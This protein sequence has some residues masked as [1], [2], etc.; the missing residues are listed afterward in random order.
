MHQELIAVPGAT[1]LAMTGS[2]VQLALVIFVALVLFAPRVIPPLLRLLGVAAS[3][4]L[5]ARRRSRRRT[6]SAAAPAPEVIPPDRPSPTLRASSDRPLGNEPPDPEP[7][8]P[9]RVGVLVAG[10][11]AVLLWFLLHSR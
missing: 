6:S 9:W 7:A 2:T 1:S 8:P 10:A 3:R 11:A 5:G 4:G